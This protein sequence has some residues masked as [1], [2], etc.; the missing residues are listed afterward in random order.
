MRIPKQGLVQFDLVSHKSWIVHKQGPCRHVLRPLLAE[1][2]MPGQQ[3]P[4]TLRKPSFSG[5]SF[6]QNKFASFILPF[7]STIPFTSATF[8]QFIKRKAM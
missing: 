7:Y 1:L 6:I 5:R 4:S 3:A 8:F 2:Q